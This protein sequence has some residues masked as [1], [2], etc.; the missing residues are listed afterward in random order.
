MNKTM[1][2]FLSQK[3]TRLTGTALVKQDAFLESQR[4]LYKG[5][6]NNVKN[7][8]AKIIQ[9]R[10]KNQL[11]KAAHRN[12]AVGPRSIISNTISDQLYREPGKIISDDFIQK[13]A[14]Q[15]DNNNDN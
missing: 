8:F 15:I 14:M 12:Q 3:K 13:D 11:A 4:P 10:L 2:S 9:L 6:F 1:L 7:K 5:I